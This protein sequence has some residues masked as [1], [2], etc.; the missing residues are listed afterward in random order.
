MPKKQSSKPQCSKKNS[1]PVCF[2]SL[3][4]MKYQVMIPLRITPEV[5]PIIAIISISGLAKTFLSRS[6][7][8]SSICI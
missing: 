6:I 2:T 1:A 3:A 7:V 4:K 5:R 8:V